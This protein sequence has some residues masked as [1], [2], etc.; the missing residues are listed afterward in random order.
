[1]HISSLCTI[2]R[3]AKSKTLCYYIARKG[4]TNEQVKTFQAPEKS[5][6]AATYMWISTNQ[7]KQFQLTQ[8]PQNQNQKNKERIQLPTNR[9][10]GIGQISDKTSLRRKGR[11]EE[12]TVSF[13]KFD[14]EDR[15]SGRSEDNEERKQKNLLR[16]T[17]CD[18]SKRGS[19]PHKA[20]P[21]ETNRHSG[22]L[23]NES[24][25]SKIRFKRGAM[26]CCR[27]EKTLWKQ[28]LQKC[29]VTNDVR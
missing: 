28:N 18:K 25:G 6:H 24:N 10:K 3:I 16:T 22:L 1:M 14:W 2:F 11:I 17:K 4:D 8:D 23:A 29:E 12:T 15:K 20:F 7:K 27:A 9:M 5:S 26:D 13:G 21:S 19:Q